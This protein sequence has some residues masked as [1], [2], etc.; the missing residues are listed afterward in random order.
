MCVTRATIEM[1]AAF[2]D[3][4]IHVCVV[5]FFAWARRLHVYHSHFVKHLEIN[6]ALLEET[7]YTKS[8]I[9]NEHDPIA[10][11][12]KV[13]KE[14]KL[15]EIGMCCLTLSKLLFEPQTNLTDPS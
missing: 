3:P 1:T 14:C 6:P 12:Q 15:E 9:T 2:S 4:P 8:T 13:V 11:G 7:Q 10:M 5:G